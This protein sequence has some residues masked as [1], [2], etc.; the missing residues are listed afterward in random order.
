MLSLRAFGIILVSSVTAI[1]IVLV[2][3]GPSPPVSL[4]VF[5]QPAPTAPRFILGDVHHA[6]FDDAGDALWNDPG[7]LLPSS[8]GSALA[9]NMTTGFHYWGDISMFHHLRCL[10]DIRTQMVRLARGDPTAAAEFVSQAGRSGSSYEALGYCFDYILQGILCY[11]DTT[12]NPVASMSDGN[13]IID[14]N[15]L[16][17][18]CR[19][20]TILRSWADVSGVPHWSGLTERL[21]Y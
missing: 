4:D 3:V 12:M 16:W 11:A 17:H 5:L 15:A 2:V 8:G 14:G 6:R 18:Q 10:R 1:L 13:K 19:D 9:T 21:A 20:D 7:A